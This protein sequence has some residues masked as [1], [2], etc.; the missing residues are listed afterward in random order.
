MV[1]CVAVDL[2]L[3][4]IVRRHGIPFLIAGELW[5]S[6]VLCGHHLSGV[7]GPCRRIPYFSRFC[8]DPATLSCSKP[9]SRITSPILPSFRFSRAANSSSSARRACRTLILICAF[10][11]PIARVLS[12]A[13][14][15]SCATKGM[16]A[17]YGVIGTSAPRYFIPGSAVCFSHAVRCLLRR[18]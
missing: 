10:H 9:H 5:C 3:K 1:S 17:D 16:P 12:Y 13:S 4:L 15:H 11:S 7:R 14:G 18:H 6:S 8:V 2:E